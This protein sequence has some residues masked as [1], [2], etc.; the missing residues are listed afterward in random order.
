MTTLEKI[1]NWF[2]IILVPV[3]LFILTPI[4]GSLFKESKS[5]EYAITHESK[6]FERNVALA[7]WPELDF[8]YKDNKFENAIITTLYIGNIGQKPVTANDFESPIYISFKTDN[9]FYGHKVAGAYPAGLSLKTKFIDNKLFINPLLLN[10][11]D[12]FY[13]NILSKS[14]LEVDKVVARIVGMDAI[15]ERK[16]KQTSGLIIDLVESAGINTTK[17]MHIQ[18]IS[19][20]FIFITSFIA[21][22]CT[23]IFLLAFK[24]SNTLAKRV[25]FGLIS[26][27]MYIL[28]I[29]LAFLIPSAI[30]S[31]AAKQWMGYVSMFGVL[32]FGA[33]VAIFIKNH[34]SNIQLIPSPEHANNNK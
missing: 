28:S 34:F 8:Q 16:I 2:A 29:K 24:N 6:V 13:I 4:W 3:A 15:T 21:A 25:M 32:L 26:L 22:I 20:L 14:K 1:V 23:F 18:K 33:I 17:Q 9:E 12:S 19:V 11:G 27:N 30:L 5:L 10:V 7:D 31:F